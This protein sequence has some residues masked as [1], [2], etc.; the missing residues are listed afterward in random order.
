MDVYISSCI[1][2]RARVCWP[3]LCLCR[4]IWIFEMS[5]CEFRKMPCH[6]G[7]LYQATHPSCL[8]TISLILYGIRIGKDD[9]CWGCNWLHPPLPPFS[10]HSDYGC[11]SF[12]SPSPLS[13]CGQ[14]EAF[15]SDKGLQR[16][17][18]YLGWPIATSYVSPNAGGGGELRGL[19]QWVQLYTGAQINFG[20]LTPYLIYAFIKAG[21]CGMEPNQVQCFAE[22]NYTCP[23]I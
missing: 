21:G 14:K 12:L 2:W 13:V 15:T 7:A 17:V 22:L 5:G 3:L 9:F 8:A 20:D 16:D 11:L 18:V 4:P 23:W 1:V 6:A 10:E 19:S